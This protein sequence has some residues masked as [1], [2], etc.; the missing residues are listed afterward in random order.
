MTLLCERLSR[1]LAAEGARH[2]TAA[3]VALAVRGLQG[4]D[5]ATFANELG[6]SPDQLARAESGNVAFDQLPPAIL[7]RANAEPQLDL[8]RLRFGTG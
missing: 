5:P 4:A 3:A 8:E 6:I 1:R 2:P 7:Q